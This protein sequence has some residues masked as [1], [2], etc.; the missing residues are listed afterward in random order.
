MGDV[1]EFKITDKILRKRL[2]HERREMLNNL[3]HVTRGF[4]FPGQDEETRT[5]FEEGYFEL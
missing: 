1:I 3:Y 5:Q 2:E 4:Q